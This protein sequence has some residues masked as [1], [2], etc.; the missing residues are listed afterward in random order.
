MGVSLLTR[1]SRHQSEETNVPRPRD[2]TSLHTCGGEAGW[3]LITEVSPIELQGFY[4][5]L[6]RQL[7]DRGV[8]CAIT[9]GLA[10]VHYGIAETTKD[11]GVEKYINESRAALVAS[12]LIPESAVT[13]L[14]DVGSYFR[15]LHE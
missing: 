15:W 7:R 9:S 11:Y 1:R 8:L 6:V 13:W 5:D 12:G 14:P 10:C 2:R 3:G 4:E